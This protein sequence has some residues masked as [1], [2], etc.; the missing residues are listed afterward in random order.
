MDSPN[1]QFGAEVEY[2]A[3][4]QGTPAWAVK[5]GPDAVPEIPLIP[6][7]AV[8]SEDFEG[9]L[10]QQLNLVSSTGWFV[11]SAD[12]HGG[13]KSLESANVGGDVTSSLV[14]N[15]FSFSPQLSFWIKAD[16]VVSADDKFEVLFDGVPVYTL[17]APLPA[18]TRIALETNF[19]F[20]IEFKFFQDF[21]FTSPFVRLDDIVFGDIDT[22]GV[23]GAPAHPLVYAPLK[24]TDDGERLKV[25][26]FL[27]DDLA[28]VNANLDSLEVKLD[29]ANASLD[30]IEAALTATIKFAR[31]RVTSI[32][33]T[34]IVPAVPGKK[35]RVL[36]Y[37]LTTQTANSA[38]DLFFKSGP[39]TDL[40]SVR[41]IDGQYPVV[42][43][44]SLA[45]PA[46]ETAT[47]QPLVIG[48]TANKSVD[49][50]LTYVEVN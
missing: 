48:M 20:N 19:A 49:G 23:P 25:E 5:P 41:D 9:T 10:W 7:A 11:T 36:G 8:N 21:P 17:E 35:I 31:L 1:S 43:A 24:L 27:E 37:M 34:T 6:G 12:A 26:P 50:H 18:W 47:G 38:V 14:I 45:A 16:M 4:D 3:L 15:D 46:F 22:P 44:G 40:A 2:R 39:A 13:T 30:A 33:D 32:G 29:A 42:Y 28:A